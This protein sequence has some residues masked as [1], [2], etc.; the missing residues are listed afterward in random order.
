MSCHIGIQQLREVSPLGV[1][2]MEDHLYYPHT[3]QREVKGVKELQIHK[4]KVK[5]RTKSHLAQAWFILDE[6]VFFH[7][8]C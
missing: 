3:A 8:I 1:V 6:L 4:A 2:V 7:L 5:M